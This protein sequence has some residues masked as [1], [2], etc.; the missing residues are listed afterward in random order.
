[1]SRAA[2]RA[3]KKIKIKRGYKNRKTYE[4]L[5]TSKNIEIN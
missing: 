1:V 5:K 2:A 3:R 4:H